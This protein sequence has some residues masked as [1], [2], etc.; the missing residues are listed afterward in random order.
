MRKIKKVLAFFLAL[1]MMISV[2]PITGV[3]IQAAVAGNELKGKVAKET[4]TTDEKSTMVKFYYDNSKTNWSEVYA[5][6]WGGD[7]TTTVKGTVTENNIYTFSVSSD[8]QNVL[9][10]NTAGTDNWD[11]QTAD[12]GAH[13][14][15]K[16]LLR[17]ILTTGQMV[18]G[19]LIQHPLQL[20]HLVLSQ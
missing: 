13:S 8:Y 2:L 16:Y 9:F 20:Q 5:Y 4:A 1:A 15:K 12:A 19:K 14:L 7:T 10:K 18:V 17:I 11:Q 6:V 3:Q